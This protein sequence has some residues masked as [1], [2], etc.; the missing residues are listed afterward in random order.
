MSKNRMGA[1]RR[2]LSQMTENLWLQFVAITTLC[3]TLT[4]FG[5]YLTLCLNIHTFLE[6]LATGASLLV[7]LNDNISSEQG[8]ILAKKLLNLKEVQQAT[9]IDKQHAMERFRQQLGSQEDLLDDLEDNPLPN[10]IELILIPGQEALDQLP[11]T[12]QNYPEVNEV[13]TSRPWLKRVDNLQTLVIQISIALGILFFIGVVLVITNTV[14]LAVYARR[15]Y[16]EVL[17]LVGASAGY[18][19]WPFIWEAVLQSIIASALA[20]LLIWCASFLWR[21]IGELPFALEWPDMINLPWQMP[22]LLMLLA[23]LSGILGGLMGVGRILRH[24][25]LK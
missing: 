8:E 11:L 10:S 21:H 13:M 15:D 1:F 20:T 18:I 24:P 7:V 14:R 6:R 5:G 17:D 12:I 22:V 3:I 19:R 16:L 9:F 2:A 23:T 25:E 4:L